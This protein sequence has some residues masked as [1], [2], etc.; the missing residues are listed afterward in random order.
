M[1]QGRSRSIL[2]VGLIA[3]V[4]AILAAAGLWYWNSGDTTTAFAALVVQTPT[5]GAQATR[6]PSQEG[7][8]GIQ[9]ARRAAKQAQKETNAA[10]LAAKL[11]AAFGTI[12]S[13]QS[14][15]VT[16]LGSDSGTKD[17][18][19]QRQNSH[20]RNRHAEREQ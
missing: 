5:P 12:Q 18:F 14:D 6:K 2:S 20:R 19:A 9:A 11:I 16:V 7:R 10:S 15:A 1:R 4:G 13:V 17:I 8:G 3:F